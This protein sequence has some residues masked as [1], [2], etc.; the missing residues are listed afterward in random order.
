M[1]HQKSAKFESSFN[2]S[3]TKCLSC[4]HSP[5]FLLL[6]IS[7]GAWLV[8]P[9][10]A[11]E[12]ISDCVIHRPYAAKGNYTSP[13]V[14]REQFNQIKHRCD[15]ANRDRELRATN[16]SNPGRL[17]SRIP[18]VKFGV[19]LATEGRDSIAQMLPAIDLAIEKVL[20]MP[21]YRGVI[22]RVI[23]ILYVD[24]LACDSLAILEKFNNKEIDVM[25]GPLNDFVLGSAARFSTALYLIP[26]VSPAASSVLLA[27][28][29]EFGMLTRI[30]F[31]YADLEWVIASTLIHFGWK[32]N[33]NTPIAMITLNP[34]TLTDKFNA[35][36]DSL[37]QEQ[38]VS[39]ALNNYKRHF[40]PSG[41]MRGILKELSKAA[42]SKPLCHPP[43]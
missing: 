35:G 16:V 14:I 43:F 8:F 39:N 19:Q 36:W 20:T 7:Y 21:A 13:D 33:A 1:R 41:S 26:I 25:F 10:I 5:T 18:I 6:C 24:W 28:K 12:V 17:K 29:N 42:R 30:Y 9:S 22:F 2:F 11:Q 23:P 38:A 34:E 4:L 32:P 15:L 37:F 40:F 31:T 3:S 27:D